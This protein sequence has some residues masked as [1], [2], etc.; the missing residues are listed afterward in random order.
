[1]LNLRVA[2]TALVRTVLRL[3]HLLMVRSRTV[4]SAFL[5]AL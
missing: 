1:M 2:Q 5:G 4:L 3:G